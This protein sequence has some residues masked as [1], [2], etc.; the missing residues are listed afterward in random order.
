[1]D[2]MSERLGEYLTNIQ[3]SIFTVS[4]RRVGT[5]WSYANM[6]H[7]YN[8]LYYI[9]DG[10][11]VIRADHEVI[12]PLSGQL[13]L[14]PEGT[15]LTTF[16]D[17]EYFSKYYCHFTASLGETRLF[18]LLKLSAVIDVKDKQAIEEQFRQLCHYAAAKN[19]TSAL[20]CKTILLGLLCTYIENSQLCK[21]ADNGHSPLDAVNVVLQ[22]IDKHLSEKLSVE[23]LA[24]LVHFH[25][26]Y[27]IQVFK[28]MVGCPPMQYITKLRFE[29]A[30]I[31]LS[32]TG[33]SVYE[34]AERVGI[35]PDYFAK[36]FRHH[37][38]MTPTEYRNRSAIM[39]Q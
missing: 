37:S 24:S 30:C 14:L 29:H 27:F 4:Y 17:D 39:P 12:Q 3:T 26:H 19:K 2:Q 32:S 34:I 33:M 31:F 35:E 28:T 36:F 6:K 23:R 10:S 13:V 38:G 25:P 7:E 16:S 18:D 1:M 5:N 15:N 11:C 22:F 9:V 20:R 21:F 8:L